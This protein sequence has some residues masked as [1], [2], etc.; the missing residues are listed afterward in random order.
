MSAQD[1]TIDDHSNEPYY[2]IVWLRASKFNLTRRGV[3]PCVGRT[4][5]IMDYVHG[6]H[7]QLTSCFVAGVPK[8]SQEACGEYVYTV[9][10]AY[11]VRY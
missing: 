7:L 5:D 6:K 8:V 4:I 11:L 3:T 1:I 9:H 2:A 10:A